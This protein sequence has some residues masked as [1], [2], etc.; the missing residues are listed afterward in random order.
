MKCH[1]NWKDGILPLTLLNDVSGYDILQCGDEWY[2]YRV[3]LI[4]LF[5]FAFA[6]VVSYHI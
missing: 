4:A 5:Y 1:D 6:H 2:V 3:V